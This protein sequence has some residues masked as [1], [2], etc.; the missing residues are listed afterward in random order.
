[1]N[2]TRFFSPSLLP[3]SDDKQELLSLALPWTLH[4][5][6][7]ISMWDTQDCRLRV[8][9]LPGLWKAKA[10]SLMWIPMSC[11]PA[12]TH[13]KELVT[14]NSS[15]TAH[16]FLHSS[17]I[18]FNTVP[19]APQKDPEYPCLLYFNSIKSVHR[20]LLPNLKWLSKFLIPGDSFK[21][22]W[23]LERVTNQRNI[24]MAC[25]LRCLKFLYTLSQMYKLGKL[26]DLQT[27][28]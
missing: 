8:L 2:V 19:L 25:V 26:R 27:S 13:R 22:I 24:S 4:D 21:I 7:R 17:I 23:V 11:L 18:F 1:M 9:S 15:E 12:L 3:N 28:H 14:G 16:R 20:E 5:K 6:A 10:A